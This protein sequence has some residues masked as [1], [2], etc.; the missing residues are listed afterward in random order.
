MS[1]IEKSISPFIA[2]QFPAFYRDQ[3]PNFV[4]FVKAYY[5]WL[6]QTNQAV[7]HARSLLD[8]QDI[9]TTAEQFIKHFK[10]QYIQSLPDTAV[11]DKRLLLK[12]VLD[13]YRAKGTPRAVELLFRVVFDEDIE[14]YVPGEYIFKPS[15]N[16]WRVPRY[17]EVSSD[18]RLLD[19]VGTQIQ[20]PSNT[21]VAMVESVESKIVNGRTVNVV[22]ISNVKGEFQRG[23]RIFQT[24]DATFTRNNTLRITGSLTAIAVS[25]GGENFSVGD[26]L[27]VVGS[28]IE[29]KAR[30]SE[31]S[32][33]FTG[34]LSYSILN[35]GTGYTTNAVVTVKSTYILNLGGLQGDIS[36]GQSVADSTTAANGIV[37]FANSSQVQVVDYS[38]TI[39]FSV[40]S[41][42]I[43]PTGNAVITRVLGGSG[44]GG[45]FR[46]GSLTNRTSVT[47]NNTR[48][49]SY[50]ST[51]LDSGVDSFSLTL[52]SISGTF[53]PGDT[54]TGVANVVQLEGFTLTTQQVANGESLSN[55]SLGITGLYVYRADG[56]RISCTGAESDLNSA[57]LVSGTILVGNTSS[58]LYEL[59]IP[60]RK[61]TI[62]GSGI[63]STVNSTAVT[64]SSVNGYF[65]ETKTLTDANTGATA[66]ISDVV[67]LSDWDLE[68][69]AV[70]R[71]NLDTLILGGLPLITLEIGTISSLSQ[72]NPGSGYV[73]RPFINVNEPRI[74]AL[75]I[76]DENDTL[77][78]NN[79]VIGAT[80][81]GGNGA[82]TAVE[83]ID[84]GYGFL[85]NESVTL[86]SANNASPVSGSSIVYRSG[87]GRGRWLNR[88]SFA[89]DIMFIQDGLFYQNYSYQVI[90]QR[91]LSSYE[92]LVRD[93]TH[94]AGVALFGA[95]RA[96]DV[97]EEDLDVVSESSI[98]QQ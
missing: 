14:I 37:S 91:M 34:S 41:S 85:D 33:T 95:Y 12:H 18:P 96:L 59:I 4:A 39:S 28:G 76:F 89:S 9:D 15:D 70:V 94:P 32:N 10:Y 44:S 84:S 75:D 25:Q 90:A 24:K 79:A 72:V 67:R 98:V 22:E 74:A 49:G 11:V 52:S 38:N 31:I 81:S 54:V 20:N 55:S 27:D 23:D 3:G 87:R 53:S 21:A 92:G 62:N 66:T 56:S 29:A 17:I 61:E 40:G 93:L 26:I 46:V 35:G 60:A 82:I 57:N 58:A 13:L 64:L 7:G 19:L 50:L 78:G 65:I 6:E 48:I 69:S 86:Q 68:D 63:V 5:E 83:V 45:I 71:D 80:I 36:V 77:Q 97:K 16:T 8:Y 51:S 88:K 1:S 42:L 47:F 30:V 2:Q 43:G 73:T